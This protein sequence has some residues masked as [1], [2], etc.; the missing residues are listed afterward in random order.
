VARVIAEV[1]E[2]VPEGKVLVLF[3]EQE[4]VVE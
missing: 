3:A 4:D 2:L 1:G